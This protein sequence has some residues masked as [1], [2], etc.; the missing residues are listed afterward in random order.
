MNRLLVNNLEDNDPESIFEEI[1]KLKIDL[2]AKLDE[3]RLINKAIV[4]EEERYFQCLDDYT[5]KAPIIF[6]NRPKNVA[7]VPKEEVLANNYLSS[8]LFYFS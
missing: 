1:Y 5:I 4:N 2:E 7:Y 6:L 8:Y 3:L